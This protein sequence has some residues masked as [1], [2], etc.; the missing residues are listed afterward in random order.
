MVA[1]V[2]GVAPNLPGLINS[3][4]SEIDVGVGVHPYQFGW[5]LGFVATSLVYVVV[6]LVFPA[7][8]SLVDV[9]VMPEEVY[10]AREREDG[11]GSLDSQEKVMREKVEA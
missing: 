3:V 7:R 8:E 6:S 5:L 11:D 10:D 4:N 2:V 1:F 9:A